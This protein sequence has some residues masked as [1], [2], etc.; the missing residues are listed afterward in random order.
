MHL[1]KGKGPEKHQEIN[2][3]DRARLIL[4]NTN[5]QKLQSSRLLHLISKTIEATLYIS[6][7]IIRYITIHK[8]TTSS[9][10]LNVEESL[11]SNVKR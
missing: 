6:Y 10:S 11:C 2:F 1:F 5:Y 7:M 9:I 8:T 3:E 4:N